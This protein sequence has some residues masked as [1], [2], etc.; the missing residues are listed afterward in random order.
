M[1]GS[2]KLWLAHNCKPRDTEAW[3]TECLNL[4]M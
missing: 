3:N 4:G 1:E 2:S